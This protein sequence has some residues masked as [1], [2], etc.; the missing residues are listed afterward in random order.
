MVQFFKNNIKLLCI[1]YLFPSNMIFAESILGN[2]RVYLDICLKASQNPIFFDNF[3]SLNDYKGTVECGGEKSDILYDF[4]LKNASADTKNHLIEF[5]ALDTVGNPDKKNYQELKNISA[6][7][8]RY[9]VFADHMQELFN[10]NNTAHIVE[11]GAGFG[12]QCFVLSKLNAFSS[13]TIYD[14]PVVQELIKKVVSKLG[15]SGVVCAPINNID[16]VGQIDLV[17]SNYAF[18]ECS[19]DIQLDYFE[20]VIKRAARG[21]IVYNSISNIFNINSLSCDE[22]VYLL[23][24]NGINAE[25]MDEFIPTQL[26][27]IKQN[28]II[29]WNTSN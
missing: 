20:K 5:E 17:I 4:L 24:K 21:Y 25:V 3:R 27:E 6:T 10:L 28:K 15:I 11:I 1:A 19:R 22:F 8:L 2:H 13:Y 18:S 14:L 23:I 12:G 7:T 16:Q 26:D 29:Y 9:I